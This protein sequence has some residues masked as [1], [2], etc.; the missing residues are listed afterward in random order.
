MTEDETKITGNP[1]FAGELLAVLSEEPFRDPLFDALRAG[2]M[3]RA[4]IKL[5]ATQAMTVVREFTR[6]ISAIHANCPHTD[7]Q[8][9][10]AENLWE[11]HGKGLAGRDHYSLIRK[12]AN[13]L[14]ATDE[15]LDRAEPL[16]ETA[17]YIDYCFKVTRESSF[18]EAMAAIGVGIE[19]FSPRF[20]GALAEMLRSQFGLAREDVEYLLVHVGEDEDH[21]RRS[22]EL[23]EKYADTSE[24]KE[25]ARQALRDMLAVKHRFARAVH[26]HCANAA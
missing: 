26:A 3:S 12:L 4:G 23:I 20:F 15:E 5:W 11:E 17:G 6:F 14:G 10:L 21:A 24:V 13:S 18:I 8:L 19:Y 2:R 25:K 22:L 1:S 7:A 16:A 9:L